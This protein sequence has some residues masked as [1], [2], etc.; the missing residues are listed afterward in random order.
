MAECPEPDCKLN[1]TTC[2]GKKIDRT[3]FWKV[4]GGFLLFCLA[5]FG[6][7]YTIYARSQ[8]KKDAQVEKIQ[9]AQQEIIIKNTVIDGRVEALQ[10]DVNRETERSKEADREQKED[11]KEILQEI[12]KINNR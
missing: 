6:T 5:A 1:F 10:R 9:K 11:L 7:G 8:D 2:L 12:R 4:V 3:F